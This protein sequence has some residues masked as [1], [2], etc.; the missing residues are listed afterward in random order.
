MNGPLDLLVGP[1]A[2]ARARGW[3]ASGYRIAQT[4]CP[5]ETAC[6]GVCLCGSE[7]LLAML[8]TLRP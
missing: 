4:G 2:E 6:P 8:P 7:G 3:K 1:A 5:A